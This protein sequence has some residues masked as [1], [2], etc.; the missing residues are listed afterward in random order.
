MSISQRPFFI[1]KKR[2]R[3]EEATMS[4]RVARIFKYYQSKKT[5]DTRLRMSK[6]Y[7]GLQKCILERNININ[8]LMHEFINIEVSLNGDGIRKFMMRLLNCD[9]FYEQW[10]PYQTWNF[11]RIC[12]EFHIN[13]TKVH[14]MYRRWVERCFQK[15]A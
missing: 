11:R 7:S 2:R 13:P 14:P 4:Q 8:E 12:L 1:I 10:L 3:M 6:V 15:A 5:G 9:T